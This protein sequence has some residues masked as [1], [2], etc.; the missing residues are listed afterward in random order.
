[1]DD[2][3][4]DARARSSTT[5][6]AAR[7]SVAAPTVLTDLADHDA[8]V[9][10]DR[11]R[12]PGRHHAAAD[13]RLRAGRHRPQAGLRDLCRRVVVHQ[14]GA[15]PRRQLDGALLAARPA[16]AR[17]RLG[18]PG[19]DEGDVGV[20]PG[21]GAR[22]RRRRLQHRRVVRV[23]ARAAARGV[24]DHRLQLAGGLRP[25]RRARPRLGRPVA[26]ALP[27]AGETRGAVGRGAASHRLRAGAAPP[28]RRHTSL[29]RKDS[30]AA[31]LLGHRAAAVPRRSDLG[32]AHVLAAALPDERRGI[33]PETDRALRLAAVPGGRYRLPDWRNH[34][35]VRSRSASASA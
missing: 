6:R 27:V 5:S 34:Q 23:D 14:H 31:Q 9:L 12:V 20:V 3:P 24:G 21:A 29:D 32:H 22:P 10:L 30:R 25:D 13:L 2:Q 7:S 33:R 11:R 26:L 8:A 19:G 16:R 4:A 15:R 28:G 17:R 35:P 1:M 18:Q